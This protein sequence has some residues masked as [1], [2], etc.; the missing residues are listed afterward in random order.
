MRIRRELFDLVLRIA[1]RDHLSAGD[2]AQMCGTSRPRAWTLLQ[3]KIERFNSETLID[4]LFRVGVVL[5]VETRATR[6][7]RRFELDNPRVAAR[8]IEPWRT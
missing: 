3:G 6:A 5:A 8:F 2:I 1:E 7:Y 4:I